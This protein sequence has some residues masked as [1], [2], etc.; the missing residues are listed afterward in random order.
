MD[1]ITMRKYANMA[2]KAYIEVAGLDKWNG[3]TDEKKHDIV[4]TMLKDAI[5]ALDKLEAME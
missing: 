4:F 1:E 5:R 2:A 3:L